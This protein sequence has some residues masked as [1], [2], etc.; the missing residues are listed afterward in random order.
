MLRRDL[1]GTGLVSSRLVLGTMTFG[2]QVDQATADAM[3]AAAFDSG[4]DHFDTA[5]AYNDGAAE[6][7]LGR[8]LGRR[9]TEAIVATKVFNKM[10]DG[11]DGAGLGAAAIASAL[12]ASLTRLRTDYVDLYYLHA[13]DRAVPLDETLGAMAGLVA[14]GKVRFV[15]FSNYAAWQVADMLHLAGSHGWPAPRIGQQLYNAISRSLDEEYA[16]FASTHGIAT[17][18]YNPLAGGLLTGKHHGLTSPPAGRFG[19]SPNYRRRYWSREQSGAVDELAGIAGRAG[20]SP[21]ELALGW[22]LARPVVDG[23]VL[24]AS[25]LDQLRV[26]LAASNGGPVDEEILDATEAIW[27]ELRGPFPRYNR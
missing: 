24:G 26:D 11:P 14:Q 10:H 20:L 8:A 9:R 1:G 4:V 3:V 17:L 16:E 23:V 5:N 21:V 25:S 2:S 22:L 27:N 13:P 15:G 18:V 7:M 12:E 19:S 6:E